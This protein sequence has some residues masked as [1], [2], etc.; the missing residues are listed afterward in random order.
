VEGQGQQGQQSQQSEFKVLVEDVDEP[1]QTHEEDGMESE[2][3][4]RSMVKADSQA[5]NGMITPRE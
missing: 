1:A 5:R 3:R 2:A 4:G